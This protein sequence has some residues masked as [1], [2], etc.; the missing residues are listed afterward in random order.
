MKTIIWKYF[1]E[2]H[3]YIEKEKKLIQHIT[4]GLKFSSDDTDE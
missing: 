1:L 2:K 3:E 4:D